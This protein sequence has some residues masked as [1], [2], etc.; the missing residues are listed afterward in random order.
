MIPCLPYLKFQF[1]YTGVFK[2]IVTAFKIIF[3]FSANQKIEKFKNI[4]LIVS[5]FFFQVSSMHTNHSIP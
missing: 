3:A 1:C 4:L 2:F 5:G